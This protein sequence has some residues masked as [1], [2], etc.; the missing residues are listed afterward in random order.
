MVVS[1]C[2]SARAAED[3]AAAGDIPFDHTIHAGELGMECLACHTFADKATV[4]GIPSASKCM[5]CH[6]FAATDKAPIKKL[7]ALVEQGKAPTWRKD[8][9][10]ADHVYFS[11]RMHVR[12]GLACQTCHGPVE[13]M[14]Q[15]QRVSSLEMGWC[16]E[17]H[18]QRQVSVDCLVCHK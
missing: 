16:L 12:T 9:A 8:Y 17:C 4:A 15:V 6:R 5:G 10:L 3:P 1:G 7:A 14:K 13:T 2:N 18:K 11:H